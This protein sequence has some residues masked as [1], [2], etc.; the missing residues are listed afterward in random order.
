MRGPARL[1]AAPA[2]RVPAPRRAACR[3]DPGAPFR[4]IGSWRLTLTPAVP[5][6]AGSEVYRHDQDRAQVLAVFTT[7]RQ[8]GS[9]RRQHA[10]VGRRAWRARS[11]RQRQL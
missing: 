4:P 2:R 8:G 5:A 6:A 7:F 1:D 10:R 11:A 3:R 9:C